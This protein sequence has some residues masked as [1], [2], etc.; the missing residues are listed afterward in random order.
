MKGKTIRCLEI[1]CPKPGKSHKKGLEHCE[2]V[3]GSPEDTPEHNRAKLEAFMLNHPGVSWDLKAIDKD[4][5]AD[6]AVDLPNS[7]SVKF[8]LRPLYEVI[9]Y[10]IK[11]GSV[12]P[13]PEGYFATPTY[14]RGS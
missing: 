7:N 8:H 13:V 11:G 12:V 9:E 3:I 5:N 10:E 6:V 4:L 14:T 2:V 1:P